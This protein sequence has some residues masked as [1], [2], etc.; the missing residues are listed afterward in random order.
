MEIARE[1][2]QRPIFTAFGIMY[3]NVAIGWRLS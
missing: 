2:F 1:I 3:E